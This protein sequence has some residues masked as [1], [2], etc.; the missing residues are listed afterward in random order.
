MGKGAEAPFMLT[1]VMKLRQREKIWCS[2]FFLSQNPTVNVPIFPYSPKKLWATLCL[3]DGWVTKLWFAAS[4]KTW[5][6]GLPAAGCQERCVFRNVKVA[7]LLKVIFSPFASK[8]GLTG[9]C[10]KINRCYRHQKQIIFWGFLISG[11]W[12]VVASRFT[13]RMEREEKK[14]LYQH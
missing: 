1:K 4:L 9:G 14:R 5:T 2:F 7:I 8:H 13:F 10:I 3:T 12:Q 11:G 6:F